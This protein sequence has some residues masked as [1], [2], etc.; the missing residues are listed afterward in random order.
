MVKQ[1][2]PKQTV[3]QIVNNELK[4]KLEH[5]EKCQPIATSSEND[6]SPHSGTTLQ[7]MNNKRERKPTGNW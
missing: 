1:L 5:D 2:F 4:V 7:Q 3:L 6:D